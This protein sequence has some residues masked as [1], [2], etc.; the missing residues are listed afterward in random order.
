MRRHDNQIASFA[1]SGSDNTF[2]WMLIL[3]VDPITSYAVCIRALNSVIEDMIRCS[4]RNGLEL[5]DRIGQMFSRFLG[6]VESRPWL[7]YCD[8]HDACIVVLGES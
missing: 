3:Y 8:N 2:S 1:F 5:T 6:H 7:R 4:N